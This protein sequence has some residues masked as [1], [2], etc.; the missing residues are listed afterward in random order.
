MTVVARVAFLRKVLWLFCTCTVI[1]VALLPL[2][3]SPAGGVP[4]FQHDWIWPAL[5]AQCVPLA[6]TGFEPWHGEA[7]GI[8]AAYPESYIY[9][10]LAGTACIALGPKFGLVVL[11]FG[12]LLFCAFG[13]RTLYYTVSTREGLSANTIAVIAVTVLAVANPAVLNKLQAGHLKFIIG[14]AALPWIAALSIRGRAVYAIGALLGI[15]TMEPQFLF[16]GVLIVAAFLV[17]GGVF[18]LRTL[19]A[20]AAIAI[21][22][23]LTL[24]AP[25]FTAHTAAAFGTVGPVLFWQRVQS[26]TIP[27]AL[28]LMGYTAH[29]ADRALPVW[30]RDL[31]WILPACVVVVL[32]PRFQPRYVAL[33]VLAAI[34][35]IIAV[36]WNSMFSPLWTYGYEHVAALALFREL[37]NAIVLTAVAFFACAAIA[38][39]VLARYSRAGVVAISIAFIVLSAETAAH[40]TSGIPS[41]AASDEPALAQVSALPGYSR[42]AAVP[43]TPPLTSPAQRGAGYSPW[44]FS[45]ADHPAFFSPGATSVLLYVNALLRDGDPTAIRWLERADVG[46]VQHLKGWSTRILPNAEPSMRKAEQP[47]FHDYTQ[48]AS[49]SITVRNASVVAVEPFSRQ[50]GSLANAY[51]GA[52]DLTPVSGGTNVQLEQFTADILPSTG[53]AQT[54]L[55][56]IM[57]AW[58]FAEPL[59]LFTTRNSATLNMPPAL[60]VVGDASGALQSRSCTL[61]RRLDEHFRVLKCGRDPVLHGRAPIIVS[62][63]RARASVPMPISSQG[64]TGS[65]DVISYRPWRITARL[66]A[67]AG[68]AIVLRESYD[69]GW[70]ISLSGARHVLVHG[71]ANAWIAATPVDG[72]VTFWYRPALVFFWC[73]G[74]SVATLIVCLAGMLYRSERFW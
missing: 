63:A 54:S 28:R 71:Y 67:A 73:L 9:H 53:W 2:I 17:Y 13:A 70:S 57:P 34:G 52:R 22:M 5:R 1:V 41:Y 3:A 36:G 35:V 65:S 26:G 33:L 19:L 38:L 21:L 49:G 61:V 43:G 23:N 39:S 18:R 68:S 64:S 62:Y 44:A 31:Y 10:A 16:F 72:V 56:P 58:V 50:P 27:E 7:L 14:Y 69:D 74:V 51:T 6:I 47:L 8:P 20:A 59:G 60:L 4:A 12:A 24:V 46:Y 15:A 11:L 48:T 25:A 30:V 29:Y 37:Y 40:C 55:V 32:L 45:F 66:K 42:F